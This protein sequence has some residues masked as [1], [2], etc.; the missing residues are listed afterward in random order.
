MVDLE[1]GRRL[2]LLAMRAMP[3][4]HKEYYDGWWLRFSQGYTGR[5]NAVTALDAGFYSL[6]RKITYCEK[7]YAEYN[8]P[9][10]FRLT[11]ISQPGNLEQ[12]LIE[13]GYVLREGDGMP[14]EIQTAGI[15]TQAIDTTSF[16]V[17]TYQRAHS[18]WMRAL[19]V[20]SD[21]PV[22]AFS[23]LGGM[24]SLIKQPVCYAM[25]SDEEQPV[26]VAIGVAEERWLGIFSVLV[27]EAYRRRGLGT[28]L[29]QVLFNWGAEQ[30]AS[31]SYLQVMENNAAAQRLY[32]KLGYQKVYRYWYRVKATP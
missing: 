23:I 3:S 15:D 17:Q 26:A 1:L 32:A 24:L 8:L 11:E 22:M 6:D 20:L 19:A 27:S 16:N 25:I 10:M 30:G 28:M 18:D 2:E 13:R 21:K 7:K 9:T 4:L 14:T 31:R 12:A 5:A 29:M